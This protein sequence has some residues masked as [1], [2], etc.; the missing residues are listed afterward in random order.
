MKELRNRYDELVD[1]LNHHSWQYYV[2]DEPEVDDAQ[3]DGWLKE[4]LQMEEDHPDWQRP[5][6]PSQRIGAEP[7]EGFSKV[8]HQSPM[9]SLED[10]F[11]P[12]ELE[13][14]LQRAEKDCGTALDWCCELKIDGL[15]VSLVYEDGLFLRGAT[16]GDGLIGEDVTS[17]LKTIGEIPLKLKKPLS[18]RLEVRGE[19]YISKEGFAELNQRREESDEALFANPRNAAAGSL[20]QLDS[21]VAASRNLRI[22][23]YYLQDPEQWGLSTQSEVLTWLAEL[24]FPV[25]HAWQVASGAKESRACI[26]QWREKRHDLPYVTDGMVCKLNDV[27]LWQQLGANA[28]TPRWA[29]AYKYPPEEKLTRLEGIEVSLGRTGVVTPVA[30]LEPVNL[31]GTVVS[32]A[33]LHNEDELRRKDVMIGDQVWVRKAG[34]IIPEVIRV[35]E[36]A[37]DG[38]QQRFNMPVDCPVCGQPLIRLEDEVALRC[39]NSSCSA[40]M[41]QKLTHFAS[42]GCM[43]IR[44]LG[45]KVASRLIEAGLVRRLD[46]LYSLTAE[47]LEGLERFGSTSAQSLIEAIDGSKKQPLRRFLAALGIRM[48]GTAVA[49]ELAR[50]FLSLGNLLNASVDDVAQVSGVGNVI[51]RSLAAWFGEEANGAMIEGFKARGLKACCNVEPSSEKMPGPLDGQTFVFTGELISMTREVAQQQVEALGG[52]AASSVSSKTNWVVAGEKAGSKL[53]KARSLGIAVLTEEEFSAMID[54]V[55]AK[56]D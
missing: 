56:K 19:V 41:L 24:G 31:S 35:E 53:T 3:W 51:A 30:L 40:Q 14:W 9:L 17:N 55:Q 46:D 26:E 28:R 37:R 12:E 16:R 48:V 8:L 2:L 34:E 32:R 49:G 52:K 5:D 36:S 20:R 47:Q 1:L 22:F 10:V 11:S 29:V 27:A 25:Q 43:D 54:Q 6:S 38:S 44:G 50:H 45:E 21:K 13:T 33:S 18:G 4:L 42:R 23:L 15:A 39:V 7:L